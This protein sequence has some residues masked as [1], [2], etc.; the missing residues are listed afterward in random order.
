M[1]SLGLVVAATLIAAAIPAAAQTN[2]DPRETYRVVTRDTQPVLY[3]WR[4]TLDY[5]QSAG[6]IEDAATRVG[7]SR[8]QEAK[9]G[10][11]FG[12]GTRGFARL[13]AGRA[14]RETKR[15]LQFDD[16]K[17]DADD[18]ALGV[19][20]GVFLLPFLA[21]GLYF[22]YRTGD[23]EDIFT[24]RAIGSAV[25]I[26]RDDTLRRTA[27]FLLLTAPVGPVQ[28]TL[29]GAYV[30]VSTETDYSN[31]PIASDSGRVK[32]SLLDAS[33]AWRTTPDIEIGGSIGW[34]HVSS[35]RV[36]ADALPLDADVG[37]AGLRVTYS[38][39][40][41]L[42]ASLRGSHDFANDRGD[43]FRFGGGLAYRF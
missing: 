1:N 43:G 37:T 33:L 25:V 28:A 22:Q 9:L 6:P 11:E 14:H 20:G 21:A 40:E 35:Q 2:A 15:A 12:V 13:E 42:D 17:G 24:N 29:L 16:L 10:L 3:S 5:G 26:G 27:P 4:A 23:G 18:T 41:A 38:L 34:T 39:T 19:T 36:Q 30:D 8:S 7:Y 31:A 32:A